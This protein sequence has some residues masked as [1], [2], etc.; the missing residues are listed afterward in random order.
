[1]TAPGSTALSFGT[2]F[3]ATLNGDAVAALP[4]DIDEVGDY[5]LVLT[6][7]GNYVGTKTYP[8]NVIGDHVRITLAQEV[9]TYS[10]DNDLNFTGSPLKAYIAAG[11]NKSENKVL[12]VRVYD[13]PAGTGIFLRGQGGESYNIPKGTSQSYYVNMLKANLTASAIA[14]TDGD[15]SNFLL[16]KVDNIFMFCAPSANAT[17][18]ANRAYLQVPTTFVS[19]NARE[20]NI[21]FEEDATGITDYTDYTGKP[22]NGWY[23]LQGRKHDKKPVTKGLYIVNGKTIVVK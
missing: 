12:L 8:I 11:Y 13:V 23:D 20:V 2:D 22:I 18:G 5:T 3:T 17:L 9:G 21:V 7:T 19:S 16:A 15:M 6:G 14:Q 1:M 4:I 10:S